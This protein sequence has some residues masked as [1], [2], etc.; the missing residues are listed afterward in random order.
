MDILK[1]TKTLAMV[2][3]FSM[4]TIMSNHSQA[5]SSTWMRTAKIK[6]Y[7]NSLRKRK[8]LPTSFICKENPSRRSSPLIKVTYKPNTSKTYWRWAWGTS[9]SDFDKPLRKYGF[10]RISYSK[11]R[12]YFGYFDKCGLW[13]KKPLK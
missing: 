13:H 1:H 10:K 8:L 7:M 2:L 11:A 3:A 4:L 5:A 6:H 9:F 12:G